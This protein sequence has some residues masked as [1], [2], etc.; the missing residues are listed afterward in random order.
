MYTY[1]FYVH[2]FCP[3]S[4]VSQLDPILNRSLVSLKTRTKAT[5][6]SFFFCSRRPCRSWCGTME[7]EDHERLPLLN[8]NASLAIIFMTSL[9]D[10]N[11]LDRM[12]QINQINYRMS[13]NALLYA[14]PLQPKFPFGKLQ[15]KYYF[16]VLNVAVLL[17]LTPQ[18]NCSIKT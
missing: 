4:K 8:Q 6:W 5:K 2:N 1:T 9:Y 7:I 11:N 10:R 13:R 15:P 12:Q 14:T 3:S 18:P 16:Y 17:E